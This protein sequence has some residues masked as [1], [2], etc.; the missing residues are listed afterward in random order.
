MSNR[1]N[2]IH[3]R[4]KK[5]N[6]PNWL[7]EKSNFELMSNNTIECGIKPGDILLFK[8]KPNDTISRIL[9]RFLKRMYRFWDGWGWHMAYVYDISDDSCIIVAESKIG[10]GVQLIKYDSHDLLGEV[11]I[12]R[13]IYEPDLSK[14]EYFTQMRM[15]CAYNLACY[16][17][18]GL[19]MLIKKFLGYTI[20]RIRNDKYTC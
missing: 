16:F 18:T 6:L 13:W 15:G 2:N 10:Q 8:K 1:Y 17:W 12:Y 7:E 11:R 4:A 9:T 5:I 3:Q 19:Q 20:P 14:L